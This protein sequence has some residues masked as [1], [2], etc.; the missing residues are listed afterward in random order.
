MVL[1]VLLAGRIL[2]VAAGWGFDLREEEWNR[3][4]F[5]VAFGTGLA[6]GGYSVARSS[7]RVAV[8]AAIAAATIVVMG[9]IHAK[10][11]GL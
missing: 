2:W 6:I 7:W 5:A 11:R 1:G 4:W 3:V 9:F 10:F 8:L